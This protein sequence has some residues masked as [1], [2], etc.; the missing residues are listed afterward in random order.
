MVGRNAI[1]PRNCICC[2]NP[3]LLK[4]NNQAYYHRKTMNSTKSS[5]NS[6]DKLSSSTDKSSFADRKVIL[7]NHLKS[8]A[9]AIKDNHNNENCPKVAVL[10]TTL[11]TSI[12]EDDCA[13]VCSVMKADEDNKTIQ[14]F[15]DEKGE[16]GSVKFTKAM[17]IVAKRYS[18]LK[19]SAAASKDR[20]EKEYLEDV[21]DAITDMSERIEENGNEVWKMTVEDLESELYYTQLKADYYRFEIERRRQYPI[22]KAVEL[23]TKYIHKLHHPEEQVVSRHTRGLIRKVIPRRPQA[24]APHNELSPP[25]VRHVNNKRPREEEDQQEGEGNINIKRS[26]DDDDGYLTPLGGTLEAN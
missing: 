3:V 23:T 6:S 10:M 24:A 26:R 9:K 20:G 1:Y 8:I 19:T 5:S 7:Q 17:E 13:K 21:I 11:D 4:N 16:I 12:S 22:L 15:V 2:E 25:I 18:E 14:V